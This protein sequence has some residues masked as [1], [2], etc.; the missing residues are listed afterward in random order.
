M[1]DHP[2]PS[3]PRGLSLD[4]A[5]GYVGISRATFQREVEAGN[6][7]KPIR[8]TQGRNI[9]L[10]EQLDRWLDSRAGTVPASLEHNP[11]H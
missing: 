8:I 2:L 5:A 6:A 9:W 4:L 10:R 3:W 11:W 7:P 1:P